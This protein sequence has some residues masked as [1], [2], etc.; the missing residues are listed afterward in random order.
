M[1]EIKFPTIP[2]E[3]AKEAG[4]LVNSLE[5]EEKEIV[6]SIIANVMVGCSQMDVPSKRALAAMLM[7]Y[8]SMAWEESSEKEKETKK[9]DLIVLSYD[10][11]SD[12]LFC[13][14]CTK[15]K[16]SRPASETRL[17]NI[18]E[19]EMSLSKRYEDIALI[20]IGLQCPTCKRT[21]E[22]TPKKGK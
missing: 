22:F 21:I 14:N 12:Y 18:T 15:R 16:P 10:E 1:T 3:L 6:K 7:V 13:G 20:T 5:Y 8:G 4:N 2:P 11:E 17:L 19:G 9:E